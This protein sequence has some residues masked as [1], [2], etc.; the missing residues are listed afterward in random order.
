MKET[1]WQ[2]AERYAKR[3]IANLE[4]GG[5]NLESIGYMHVAKLA[6]RDGVEAGRRDAKKDYGMSKA[7]ATKLL[8][9]AQE[10]ARILSKPN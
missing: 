9:L 10:R 6:Y 4:S 5:G 8:A 3:L 7:T 1:K 2:R